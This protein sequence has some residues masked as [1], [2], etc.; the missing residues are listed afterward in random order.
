[1]LDFES[2]LKEYKDKLS[3]IF[4]RDL[5]TNK[6]SLKRGIADEDL[7]SILSPTPLAAFIPSNYG[8]FG[9]HTAEALAMLEASSYESLPLSLMMG[10]NGALFIQPV[11]NYA[12]EG[13]KE[14][15][16]QRIL[17]DRKMGGLMITE[18]D[19]GSEALKMETSFVREIATDSYSI[20]GLKHWAGLTGKADYWLMT[21]RE[22]SKDGQLGR[23][24]SFFIHDTRNGGINV[25]EYYNNLGLYPIPYGKNR[26]NIEVPSEYKLEPKGTGITLM[27]DL[28]HRSRLQFPGMG[29]GF[30]RRM[31]DEAITH[32]RQRFVGGR[33]LIDYDQVKS[34][35]N[36]LQSY[37]TVCSAM[38]NFTSL[39]I[40]LE[41]NTAKMDVEA[42]AIKS[43]ITDYMQKASQ[44][45]LQLTGA[46]GY[47]LDHIAGR[48]TVDSRPFQIFEGSNDILYQQISESVLKMMRKFKST[49]LYDFLKN[50]ELT[51]N[52]SDYFKEG[53]N[54]EIDAKMPQ[55]KLVEL[56]RALG[57]I[58][59]ME[60]TIN[61]GEQ[62]FNSEMIDNALAVLQEEVDNLLNSFKSS[63][64]LEVV[65]DYLT[66][67][68]WFSLATVDAR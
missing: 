49:N 40:P 4:K 36:K 19:F 41:K 37:F 68:N 39:N 24:I 65:E 55:R 14:E 7:A 62:G 21:A 51:I 63:Q 12:Q 38:C 27:L 50:Y 54:F 1:M 29:A 20:K 17:N 35:I 32:C 6:D 42:N 15:I 56:G 59:S 48:S 67:S 52:A 3:K 25:E 26:V 66:E 13:T 16:Y 5:E 23:D 11:A 58:I 34:R 30:L 57:R 61:L 33:R 44:S 31:M 45:L 10:I 9:G 18:P 60:F 53:L 28:L 43:V 2:F 47:R 22:K 64:I 8:G 46:K